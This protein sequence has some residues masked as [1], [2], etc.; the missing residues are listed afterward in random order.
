MYGDLNAQL[1]AWKLTRVE[2][3][4][5]DLI[6]SHK[7]CFLLSCSLSGHKTKSSEAVLRD[8]EDANGEA[9]V[10]LAAP[11][12]GVDTRTY[13]WPIYFKRGMF[14]DVGGDV[15]GITVQILVDKNY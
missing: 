1:E 13:P 11:T 4:L 3:T 14:I 8:G 2:S 5:V 12:S 7:P 15:E 10:Y 9:K 6:V